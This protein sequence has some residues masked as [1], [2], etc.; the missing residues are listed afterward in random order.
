MGI[1][2]VLSIVA[3]IVSVI[4]GGF[5]IWLAVKF[6]EMS[7]KNSEKLERSSNNIS[8]ATSRL[9]TLFE[10]LYSDTFSMVKDTVSDM[11]QH[12]WKK[13]EESPDDQKANE[14]K[15]RLFKE[16]SELIRKEIPKERSDLVEK[17]LKESINKA[18]PKMDADIEDERIVEAIKFIQSNSS[19][20]NVY[21]IS[22]YLRER[23]EPVAHA[24]LRMGETNIVKWKGMENGGISSSERIDLPS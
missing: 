20:A 3:S 23:P 21:S 24:L 8:S 2:E 10:K 1:L 13:N 15:E 19:V 6:Y 16:L 7:T 14:I 9:E 18:V 5:A 11:R 17:E 22:A 4:I 12:V